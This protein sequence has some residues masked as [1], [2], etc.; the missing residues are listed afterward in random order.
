M[1]GY[2]AKILE[3]DSES[4]AL[5]GGAAS[6]NEEEF[7][8]A[9]SL[10]G[11]GRGRTPKGGDEILGGLT[12]KQAKKMIEQK[13]AQTSSGKR[14]KGKLG[15]NK[16]INPNGMT[17]EEL[18]AEQERLFGLARDYNYEGANVDGM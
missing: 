10:K 6:S 3:L 18:I 13:L 14:R 12:E 9:Q 2:L 4:G 1:N 17:E 15:L 16:G 7:A 11:R 8:S 5:G